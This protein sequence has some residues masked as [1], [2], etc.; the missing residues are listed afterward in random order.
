[1]LNK[2]HARKVSKPDMPKSVLVV[3][4]EY[5]VKEIAKKRLEQLGY[6]VNMASNGQEAL[7]ALESTT[8]DLILLDIQMPNMNGY[9]FMIEK[10]K[11]PKWDHVP[12]IVMSA[13]EQ[14]EPIFRRHQ[15]KDYLVKPLHLHDLIDKVKQTLG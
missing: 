3:D 14:M 4:D 2:L 7:K 11:N 5:D 10:G 13:Y 1:M 15:I 8:P 12:V 9:T 6:I